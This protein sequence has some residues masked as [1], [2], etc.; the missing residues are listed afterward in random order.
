MYVSIK[1]TNPC[2]LQVHKHFLMGRTI[3]HYVNSIDQLWMTWER[4][5]DTDP[6]DYGCVED[7]VESEVGVGSQTSFQIGV[8]MMHHHRQMYPA[9]G[10]HHLPKLML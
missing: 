4:W 1:E 5:H 6:N 8:R 2:D 9:C 10:I 7:R 3:T